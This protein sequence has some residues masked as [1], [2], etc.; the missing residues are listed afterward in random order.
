MNEQ[1]FSPSPITE[2]AVAFGLNTEPKQEKRKRSC[3]CSHFESFKN[4][5]YKHIR[6]WESLMFLLPREYC[7]ILFEDPKLKKYAENL[8]D[9][10][11]SLICTSML[12]NQEQ[13][14][15]EPE[16]KTTYVSTCS[17]STQPSSGYR[18]SSTILTDSGG[19]PFRYDDQAKQYVNRPPLP[20]GILR[21]P[22]LQNIKSRKN[23]MNTKRWG[24]LFIFVETRIHWFQLFF[25]LDFTVGTVC[26]SCEMTIRRLLKNEDRCLRSLEYRLKEFV[27]FIYL[28]L[29][30]E[31]KGRERYQL[32]RTDCVIESSS[33]L[34]KI[35][36]RFRTC[37]CM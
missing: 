26:S 37:L 2:Y 14:S 28:L 5:D 23:L 10:G 12:N 27:N 29:H 22:V 1:K 30:C 19:S 11:Q 32:L 17:T 7:Q 36:Y 8:D 15:V 25:Y 20:K 4:R 31:M 6:D 21:N 33:L 35:G 34:C 3:S 24:Y 18:G 13:N 9:L 16:V